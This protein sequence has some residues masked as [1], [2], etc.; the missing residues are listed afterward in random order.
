MKIPCT[1]WIP[2][3]SGIIIDRS[4]HVE[5]NPVAEKNS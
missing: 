4:R 5:I 1:K 3:L 2:A